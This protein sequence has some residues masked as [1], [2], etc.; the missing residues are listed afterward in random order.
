MRFREQAQCE[1]VGRVSDEGRSP[2]QAELNANTSGALANR[3]ADLRVRLF[4]EN[5]N[6]T[7]IGIALPIIAGSI[8][9]EAAISLVPFRSLD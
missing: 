9:T 5:L 4:M 6:A 7:V 8:R 3:G 2:G 1:S